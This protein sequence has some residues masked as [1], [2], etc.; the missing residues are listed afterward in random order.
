[1]KSVCL[2]DSAFVQ[3]NLP[4]F[5]ALSTWKSLRSNLET[6][7]QEA[8]RF[9]AFQGGFPV[10]LHIK[11]VR[12]QARRSWCGLKDGSWVTSHSLEANRFLALFGWR[13]NDQKCCWIVN[14]LVE[15]TFFFF[16]VVTLRCLYPEC[17]PWCCMLVL[18][19]PQLGRGGL[20]GSVCWSGRWGRLGSHGDLETK[21]GEPTAVQHLGGNPLVFHS[22]Y[23][24]IYIHC[25]L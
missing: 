18:D 5:L 3:Y 20:P 24:Y 19:D 12:I 4:V 7:A 25:T 1:M 14:F 21:W 13:G 22:I 11:R 15:G 6:Q 16:F 9:H 23:T 8:E 10:D 17:L 2:A